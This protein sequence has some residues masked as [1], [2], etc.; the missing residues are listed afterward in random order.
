M[1]LRSKLLLA[2]QFFCFA[3]FIFFEDL[4]S[5]GLTILVQFAGFVL[6][7]WSI[8]VMGIGNF[9]AQPE[10]K[11]GARLVTVGPYSRVRNPMYSS[12]ILFFGSIF[13]RNDRWSMFLS[14]YNWFGFFVFLTM[15]LTFI[16]KSKDEEKFL[17]EK[18]GEK[19]DSYKG[20]THRF[21]PFLF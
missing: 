11:Q 17:S 2:I 8:S 1:S 16:L 5:S 21:F 10:V 20:S 12:L 19:Y 4:I 7:L 9:N 18:F 13:L 14:D 6:C 3:Y 15:I